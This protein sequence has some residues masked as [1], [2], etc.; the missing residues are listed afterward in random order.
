MER[1]ACYGVLDKVFPRG[2]EG[3]R[4]V[5][6]VCLDCPERLMCLKTAIRTKEGLEMRSE[7][8]KRMPAMGMLD[9][10]KRW[11]QKKEL[12]RLLYEKRKND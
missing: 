5:P 4:A 9:R 1:K 6:S 3:L 12:S 7:N 11:S 8:L 10:I 2:K